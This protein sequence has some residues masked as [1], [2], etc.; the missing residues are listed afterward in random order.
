MKF[1]P[2]HRKIFGTV[3]VNDKGQIVIPAEARKE[4][5]IEPDTKLMVF[6]WGCGSRKALFLMNSED[7]E[8][9][10]TGFWGSF[11]RSGRDGQAE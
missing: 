11:F 7:F 1:D 10:L 5:G 9:R 2:G 8:K 3:S 6:G 4:F